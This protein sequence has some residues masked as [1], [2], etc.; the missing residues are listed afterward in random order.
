LG[1]SVP[2][3]FKAQLSS[4]AIVIGIY[5]VT[6]YQY[7]GDIPPPGKLTRKWIWLS[8]PSP[9]VSMVSSPNTDA[10]HPGT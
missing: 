8:E 7:S 2:S 10:Y 3:S 4:L 6:E 1:C 9:N 5:E